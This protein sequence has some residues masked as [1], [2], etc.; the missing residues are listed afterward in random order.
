MSISQHLQRIAVSESLT[1]SVKVLIQHL[2][3][4]NIEKASKIRQL[5]SQMQQMTINVRELERFESKDWLIFHNLPVAVHSSFVS[6]TVAFIRDALQVYIVEEHLKAC[7][8]WGKRDNRK[9]PGIIAKILYND[10]K[11]RV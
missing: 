7:L 2:V 9:A 8:L 3:T 11:D 1:Q 4:E 5:E 6:D 10:L